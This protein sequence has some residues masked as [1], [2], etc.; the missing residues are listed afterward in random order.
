MRHK[1]ECD[2]NWSQGDHVKCNCGAAHIEELQ[3]QLSAAQAREAELR[4]CVA[5]LLYFVPYEKPEMGP[6]PHWIVEIKQR[7]QACLKK[8]EAMKGGDV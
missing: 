7:A 2:T 4:K 8:V 3:K 1:Y 5:E 6:L